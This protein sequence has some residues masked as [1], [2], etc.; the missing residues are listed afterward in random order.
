MPRNHRQIFA[1]AI[2]CAVLKIS[3]IGNSDTRLVEALKAKGPAIVRVLM[4]KVNELMIQLQSYIVSQKLSG[5]AL[6][7]QTGVLAGS[8]RYVPATLE[9]TSIVGAVEGGGGGAWYG[10]LYEDVSAGGTGGVSHSW[11]ITATKARA[12]SFL[13]DGKRLYR[14]SVTHPALMA[15]PYM[16][17]SLEENAGEIETQLRA[18]LDA[19]LNKS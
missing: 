11:T 14:H 13:V 19:E 17:P 15:R 5:Q 6:K 18:A 12:L 9:G 8:I 4:S 16:T 1:H 3:F 10:A 7:R 2:K